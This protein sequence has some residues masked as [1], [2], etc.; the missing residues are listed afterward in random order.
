MIGGRP[1]NLSNTVY[2]HNFEALDC[3]APLRSEAMGANLEIRRFIQHGKRFG[4]LEV[5]LFT[6]HQSKLN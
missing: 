4:S 5:D 1:C 6:F 2:D 3:L